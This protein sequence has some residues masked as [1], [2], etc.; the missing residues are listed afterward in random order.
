MSSPC[1]RRR[2][3]CLRCRPTQ[4]ATSRGSAFRLPCLSSV[5]K[6]TSQ[7]AAH[8]VANR[9]L[10]SRPPLYEEG[11]CV[12]SSVVGVAQSGRALWW[13]VGSGAHLSIASS[14]G[15]TWPM[16]VRCGGASPWGPSGGQ[17][18]GGACRS[19]GLV[20][21]EHVPDRFGESA[22]E[23]DLGDL[24]PPLLAD[25]GLCPLVALAVSGV[26]AGVDGGLDE[27][28]A[29]VLG[30]LFGER[31]APIGLAR[32]VD[33]WAETAVAGELA[34]GGEAIDVAEL[35]G[36]RVGEHPA[37]AGDGEE[38]GDVAVVGAEPAQLAL[39]AVDLAIELIDQTQARL[40]VAA[41]GLGQRQPGEQVAAADAE[42]V[43]DGAGLAVGEQDRVHALL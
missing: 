42:Q 4:G 10:L 13:W 26:R 23:V 41:P 14:V 8:R 2:R 37:D 16:G 24:G 9:R 35:G 30:P 43:G 22:G 27:R 17:G 21:G 19:E 12:K 34:R 31:A 39:A 20:A 36:D 28:P 25:S 6:R 3:S 15:R 18:V 1:A 33:A 7:S 32:L 11:P 38:Q 5:S 29:Q 40:H